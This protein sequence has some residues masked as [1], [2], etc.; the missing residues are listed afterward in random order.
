MEHILKR[1]KAHLPGRG[2]PRLMVSVAVALLLLS[3]LGVSVARTTRAATPGEGSA[4]AGFARDMAT[5]HAQA[6][7]MAVIVRERTDDPMVAGL[8]LDIVL[9]QQSQIGR[10]NGWLDVWGLPATGLDRPMAWMGH[11]VAG[12]MPGMASPE[13]IEWLTELSGEEA[14]L[15]FL[16]LMIRH[17][18]GGVPMAQ[19]LLERSEDEV[20]RR[21]ASSILRSQQAEVRIM[22]EMIARIDNGPPVSAP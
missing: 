20:V 19:A 11:P 12:R 10:M 15:E 17:H 13:E 14:D 2:W 7:E 6:V 18:E 22:Q 1:E 16:R 4:E 21:L 8:A 9:T 3:G 5:H